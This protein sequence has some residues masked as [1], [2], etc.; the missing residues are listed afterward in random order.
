[1]RDVVWSLAALDDLDGIVA[2][3]AADN[4]RAALHVVDR[5]DTSA[6]ALGQMATGR[7]GRVFGTYEKIV[8][9]LPYIVA[10]AIEPRADGSERIVILRVIHDARDWKPG[11][12]PKR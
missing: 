9:G 5:I 4:A 1:V 6:G 12:W 2:Y 8:V 10:Y 3:I 7:P 11:E